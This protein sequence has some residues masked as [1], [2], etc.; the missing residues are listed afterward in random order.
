MALV[1]LLFKKKSYVRQLQILQ[2]LLGYAQV[3]NKDINEND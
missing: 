2:Y 3:G 1:D